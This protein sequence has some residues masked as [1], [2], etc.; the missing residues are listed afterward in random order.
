MIICQ[1]IFAPGTYDDD[2]H[3][4]DGRID[5]YARSL[6]G[7]RTTETWKSADGKVVNATY[8]LDDM[9]SVRELSR[10]P[11]HLEAKGQ[12]QRWYDGYRI[13]VSEVTASYGDDRLPHVTRDDG[14]ERA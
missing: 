3:A 13:V 11:Q 2:F 4:L 6:P 9:A 14:E 1:F 10:F 8:Y 5:A 12:D 7:F